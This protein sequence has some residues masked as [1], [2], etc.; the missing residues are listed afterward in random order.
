MVN[1]TAMLTL[2]KPTFIEQN[3]GVTESEFRMN[4]VR[5]ADE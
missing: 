3:S 1:L 4:S 2:N 5:V